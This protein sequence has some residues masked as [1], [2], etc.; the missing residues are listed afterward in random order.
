MTS[1]VRAPS[2]FGSPVATACATKAAGCS[3]S[4]LGIS[5]GIGLVAAVLGAMLLLLLYR[6]EK[7]T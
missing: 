3:A 6:M 7:R 5:G 1:P 2:L 4:G